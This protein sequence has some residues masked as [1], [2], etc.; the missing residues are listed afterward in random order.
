M[1]IKN[2]AVAIVILS[3]A[4]LFAQS[5]PSP[6]P[7][8]SVPGGMPTMPMSR[9]GA[10]RGLQ[11]ATMPTAG[12]MASQQMKELED[13]VNKMQALLKQMQTIAAKSKS[14]ATQDD[15]RMWELLVGHL[16]QTLAQD[17]LLAVEHAE[18]MARREALYKQAQAKADAEA[19]RVQADKFGTASAPQNS[20]P[21]AS[22]PTAPAPAGQDAVARQ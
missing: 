10:R 2:T 3:A 9:A 8:A 21:S 5:V 1:R 16:N 18:M 12:A 17:R 19:A 7:T 11:R 22:S 4:S 14:R 20:A 13:T 6:A 15:L